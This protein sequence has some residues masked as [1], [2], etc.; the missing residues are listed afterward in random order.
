[1]KTI[2]EKRADK[3]AQY[4]CKRFDGYIS[5]DEILVRSGRWGW[6]VVWEAG[7]YDWP[8]LVSANIAGYAA[9]DEEF[10][11][12]WKPDGTEPTD[13]FVEPNTTYS[14]GVHAPWGEDR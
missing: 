8:A 7:P 1:M 6:E 3:V 4:I 9:H 11:F 14:L 13:V 2:A 10:G 5:P 12:T